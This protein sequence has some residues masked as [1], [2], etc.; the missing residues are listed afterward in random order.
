MAVWDLVDKG[1]RKRLNYGQFLI[2]CRLCLDAKHVSEV[3]TV[4]NTSLTQHLDSVPPI[5]LAVAENEER[6]DFLAIDGMRSDIVKE[7]ECRFDSEYVPTQEAIC[8]AIGLLAL[9]HENH[10]A[11]RA[12]CKTD[13][14]IERLTGNLRVEAKRHIASYL[15][16]VSS[17]NCG[18]FINSLSSLTEI[19]LDIDDPVTVS[20]LGACIANCAC[21]A[22]CSEILLKSSSGVSF[23]RGCFDRS[24]LWTDSI[25]L[26]LNLCAAVGLTRP[27]YQVRHLL[28]VIFRQGSDHGLTNIDKVGLKY[29]FELMT[30]IWG[31]STYQRF[32]IHNCKVVEAVHHFL[33]SDIQQ[34]HD[35]APGLSLLLCK[36][37]SVQ[38]NLNHFVAQNGIRLTAR[39]YLA[40]SLDEIVRLNVVLIACALSESPRSD[41]YVADLVAFGF[42]EIL[43][44][45]CEHETHVEI[46]SRALDAWIRL[47]TYSSEW[48]S[49]ILTAIALLHSE[50]VDIKLKALAVALKLIEYPNQRLVFCEFGQTKISCLH[51]LLSSLPNVDSNS[52]LKIHFSSVSPELRDDCICSILLVVNALANDPDELIQNTLRECNTIDCLFQVYSNVSGDAQNIIADTMAVLCVKNNESLNGSTKLMHSIVEIISSRIISSDTCLRAIAEIVKDPIHVTVMSKHIP[53]LLKTEAIESLPKER[54]DCIS[55]ILFNWLKTYSR[56]PITLGASRAE[57]VDFLFTLLR[58]SSETAQLYSL[59]AIHVLL[60]APVRSWLDWIGIPSHIFSLARHSNNTC[61]TQKLVIFR[62][63]SLIALSGPRMPDLLVD[64]MGQELSKFIRSLVERPSTENVIQLSLVVKTNRVRLVLPNIPGFLD[65]AFEQIRDGGLKELVDLV[66]RG[67]QVRSERMIRQISFLFIMTQIETNDPRFDQ[68]AL[69]IF[70]GLNMSNPSRIDPMKNNQLDLMKLLCLAVIQSSRA[71]LQL[72]MSL[73]KARCYKFSEYATACR[74]LNGDNPIAAYA[75]L[76]GRLR[77]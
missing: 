42:R 53:S 36:A 43:R 25:R 59:R 61:S 63:V 60:L 21:D 69:D 48:G 41:D 64:C 12:F 74:K 72:P 22:A 47:A 37:C 56:H 51:M 50:S 6:L 55:A 16:S 45:A 35:L 33:V 75:E 2:A 66:S 15:C 62:I 76:I 68:I 10:E 4:I 23:L 24:A 58:N 28:N 20:Y 71:I 46:L 7:A 8:E 3:P 13:V 77:D 1:R 5:A 38:E 29:L 19:A 18:L 31:S 11:L 70:Q 44:N 27:E 26:H 39:L 54:A 67:K 17:T 52:K 34:H 65:N 9:R 32:L 30:L 40:F 14:L 57:I 49:G 73:V